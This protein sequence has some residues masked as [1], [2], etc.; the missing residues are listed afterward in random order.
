MEGMVDH[1]EGHQTVVLENKKLCGACVNC[2]LQE[3]LFV[4]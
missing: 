2:S 1:V 3:I 4:I